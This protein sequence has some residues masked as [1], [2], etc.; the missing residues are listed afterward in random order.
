MKEEYLDYCRVKKIFDK[1][2]GFLTSLYFPENVFFHFSKIKDPTVKKELE[3]LNRG[4]V[5]L[6]YTSEAVKGKRRVDKIWFDL[7]DVEPSLINPFVMKII[8]ELDESKINIFELTHVIFLL[9]QA[10]VLNKNQFEKVLNAATV[11][12]IPT[13]IIPMLTKNELEKIGNLDELIEM[14][15]DDNLSYSGLIKIIVEN[16][17]SGEDTQK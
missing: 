3:K 11:R 8:A 6:F 15:Q 14:M 17:A 2:Y 4:A 1:G 16:L 12:K 10:G 13:A 9:R 5:Y 7:K